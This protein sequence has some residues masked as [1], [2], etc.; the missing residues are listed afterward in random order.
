LHNLHA[1][2]LAT[3][4]LVASTIF[5]LAVSPRLKNADTTDVH[6]VGAVSQL[7]I[8][9]K[10]GNPDIDFKNGNPEKNLNSRQSRK[11]AIQ[12]RI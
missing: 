7:E 11:M 5:V 2:Y 3:T 9:F 6:S 1:D 12:R 4:I 10:N 8:D